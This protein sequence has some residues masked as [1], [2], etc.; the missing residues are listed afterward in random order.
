MV[1]RS[2]KV[3]DPELDAAFADVLPRGVESF[4][5]TTGSGSAL[6]EATLMAPRGA[7]AHAAPQV[8]QRHPGKGGY[9]LN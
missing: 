4:D 6:M 1:A 8:I 7:V 9:G 2:I 5:M 3:S